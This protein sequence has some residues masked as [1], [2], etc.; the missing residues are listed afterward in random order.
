M[1]EIISK[2]NLRHYDILFGISTFKSSH[3]A[4]RLL[5][6]IPKVQGKHIAFIVSPVIEDL[7]EIKNSLNEVSTDVVLF[8]SKIDNLAL[9]RAWGFVWAIN[10]GIVARYYCSCD[11][12]IEFTENSKYILERL[13]KAYSTLGFSIMAFDSSHPYRYPYFKQK[14]DYLKI[15]PPFIDGNCM[16]SRFSDNILY[17]VMD[18]PLEAPSVFY[19]EVE[20]LHRMMYFTNKPGIVD[21]EK[22]FYLHHIRVDPKTQPI[23]QERYESRDK[24]G[25][26]FWEQKFGLKNLN[27]IDDF[28]YYD[29][30]NLLINSE[31]KENFKKHLIFKGTWNKWDE[32]YS[33][34]RNDFQLI[35]KQF[36]KEKNVITNQFIYENKIVERDNISYSKINRFDK[37]STLDELI[38]L[39]LY[40]P[41]IPLRLHLGCGE[42][43]LPGYINIDFPPEEHPIMKVKAD[44][45]ED[46]NKLTFPPESVDEIRL[47]HVFEHFDRT[48]SIALLIIWNKWLKIG[49]KL[50]IETPDVKACAQVLVSDSNLKIKQAIIRHM[51]GSQEASWAYHLDGWYDEKFKFILE[52]LGFEVSCRTWS[53][54]KWPFLPNIE[55]VAI[56][57]LN[58]NLEQ[59]LGFAKNILYNYLVDLNE[60][61]LKLYEIWS[62]KLSKMISEQTPSNTKSSI[63]ETNLKKEQ[64]N[65]QKVNNLKIIKQTENTI[66][67]GYNQDNPETNGEYLVVNSLIKQGDIVFDIG[68][69]LGRWSEFV[70]SKKNNVQI[71]LFEPILDLFL[72]LQKKFRNTNAKIFNIAFLDKKDKR[73]FYF[74]DKLPELSTFFKRSQELEN[75]LGLESKILNLYTTTIDLFCREQGIDRINYVKIDTEGSE[76]FILKGSENMLRNQSIDII[77]FEYG[78]TFV[79]SNTKLFHIWNLLCN[80]GYKLFRIYPDGLIFISEWENYLENFQYSNYLAIKKELISNLIM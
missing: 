80:Y 36:V 51:F 63:A 39:G 4:I 68:A 2:A 77:Q 3:L 79:E 35:H 17:G 41:T 16:F 23:R 25:K 31:K 61:E 70:I 54:Q 34:F 78:G 67:L 52:N 72:N 13:D 38:S 6:S 24:A 56:K 45:Y 48:T 10:N 11:D 57:K 64:D 71:Y 65:E 14:I 69:N 76:Y 27:F 37:K 50:H 8:H 44:F 26:F 66:H 40:N 19:T 55:V 12:D 60:S 18:A 62:D 33:E 32:I 28:E 74:Y 43:Y 1:S 58:Y 42:N 46:I 5:K 49:G 59:L 73:N 7:V 22:E 30:Y 53:W 21:C 9:G 29:I 15:N 75:R 47:H 20:Y